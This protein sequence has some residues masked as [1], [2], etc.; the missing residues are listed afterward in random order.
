MVA[1][2]PKDCSILHIY[3]FVYGFSNSEMVPASF[4]LHIRLAVVTLSVLPIYRCLCF[5][6]ICAMKMMRHI[7]Y[8]A[9]ATLLSVFVLL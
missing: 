7:C 9:A 6:G 5:I 3:V 8:I 2:N 4:I 1:D